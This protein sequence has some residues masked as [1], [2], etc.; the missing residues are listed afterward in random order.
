MIRRFS[1]LAAFLLVAG[2][3]D[4][5]HSEFVT[6]Q[7]VDLHLSQAHDAAVTARVP[8]GTPVEPLGWVGSECE[9][10]LVA[11]PFGAGFVFTRFLD[12][13]LADASGG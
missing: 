8:R 9:C 1:V 13:H 5:T 6:N 3:V 7:E 11:T 2:C 4:Y 10:W 12:M